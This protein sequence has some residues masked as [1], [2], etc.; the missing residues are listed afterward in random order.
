MSENPTTTKKP[1]D[2]TQDNPYESAFD[3]F[4]FDHTGIRIAAVTGSVLSALFAAKRTIERQFYDENKK[5]QPYAQYYNERRKAIDENGLGLEGKRFGSTTDQ[6]VKGDASITAE[7]FKKVSKGIEE[8][9]RKEFKRINGLKEIPTEGVAGFFKGPIKKAAFLSPG[10]AQKIAFNTLG[11]FGVTFG[12][13]MAVR[14]I[15]RFRHQLNV[16]DDK[17]DRLTYDLDNSPH[18]PS[19]ERPIEDKTI[20]QLR[21]LE[22]LQKQLDAKEATHATG[23]A[24]S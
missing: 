22:A 3:K 24:R 14:Q 13:Y 23:V 7:E 19:G 21:N 1:F 20:H 5:K 9:W 10:D 12:V 15:S 4:L 6:I 17:L 8:T 16:I 18:R 2:P 11:T